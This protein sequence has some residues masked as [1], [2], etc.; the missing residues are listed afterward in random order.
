[1]KKFED[2]MDDLV[3]QMNGMGDLTVSMLERA[4]DAFDNRD[5]EAAK[6]IYNDF[7]VL[8]RMDS[9]I[10]EL[11]LKILSLYQ[12]TAVDVRTVATILKGITYLER[13]GKYSLNIAKAAIK[14]SPDLPF[15][16]VSELQEMEKMALEMTTIAVNG[17]KNKTIENFDRIREL[18]HHLDEYR[19]TVLMCLVEYLKVRPE[20][21]EE[22]TKYLSVARHLERIGDHACKMAEKVIYMVAGKQIQIDP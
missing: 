6:T 22:Y 16:K 11:A 21:A 8:S 17:F 2:E 18:E 3:N 15:R 7:A 5:S 1:M 4:I 12:P 13:I 14:L 20:L 10:E 9:D 19:K